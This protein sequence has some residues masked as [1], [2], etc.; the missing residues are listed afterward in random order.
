MESDKPQGMHKDLQNLL[1]L[2]DRDVKLQSLEATLRAIPVDVEKEGKKL[3]LDQEKLA[4]LTEELKLKEVEASTL[5]L[6]R[7]VR[8]DTVEKLKNQLYETGKESERAALEAEVQRYEAIISD[9]ETE[10]LVLLEDI[11]E[12]KL[13]VAEQE[14]ALKKREELTT[15]HVDELKEKARVFMGKFKEAKVARQT[16]AEAVASDS[17]DLYE[18]IYKSKGDVAVVELKNEV[19]LGCDMKV[20]PSTLANVRAGTQLTKCENCSRI[21]FEI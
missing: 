18:R 5:K 11:D 21:L 16:A 14:D 20:V 4:T 10:E 15:T 7:R 17:L 13:A 12:R 1:V 9:Y 3:K 2:Q 6:E 19:C 8:Q